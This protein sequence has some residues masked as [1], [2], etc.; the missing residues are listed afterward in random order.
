MYDNR[1]ICS[2]ANQPTKSKEYVTSPEKCIEGRPVQT[3]HEQFVSADRRFSVGIWECSV[4][5]FTVNFTGYELAHLLEGRILIEDALG[6]QMLFLPGMQLVF[7]V[8]YKGLWNVLEP[9]R[10]AYVW[11]ELSASVI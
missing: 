3:F 10:K 9:S 4:G 7:P 6:G 11:Y 8:G 5:S 2:L 1:H